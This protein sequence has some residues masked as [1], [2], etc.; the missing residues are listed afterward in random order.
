MSAYIQYTTPMIEE[1]VLITA[2]CEMGFSREHIETHQSAATLV[3]FE[4]RI[5]PEKG[6]I[7]IRR[8]HVGMASNDIG[9]IKE[10]GGYRMIISA[11]DRSKY[12][13]TWR[14][15]LQDAYNN[16]LSVHIQKMSGLEAKQQQRRQ[17]NLV[18][19][20][21]QQIYKEAKKRGYKVTES[22]VDGKVRLVLVKR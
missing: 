18:T 6:H 22:K 16:N 12:N 13:E 4:G 15:R 8:Q 2:L 17:Q 5:R 20:Q 11:Y 10:E 14:K 3:G 21:K 1:D 7:V 19:Y 9:F